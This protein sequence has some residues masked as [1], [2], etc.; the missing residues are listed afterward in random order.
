[1]LA[2]EV[3][4]A[5]YCGGDEYGDSQDGV[6]REKVGLLEL[7][8]KICLFPALAGTRDY[9]CSE[10][11]SMNTY[12]HSQR[13]YQGD[14]LHDTPEGEEESC[15]HLGDCDGLTVATAARLTNLLIARS[16]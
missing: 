15:N 12:K 1:M 2:A 6:W 7:M 3:F 5:V 16:E 9:R 10:G 11:K 4:N 8:N 14:Y 13:R